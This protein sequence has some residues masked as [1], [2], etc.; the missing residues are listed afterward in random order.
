MISKFFPMDL[1][2]GKRKKIV[3]HHE[4]YGTGIKGVHDMK[5]AGHFALNS[6]MTRLRALFYFPFM[7]L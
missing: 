2:L 4:L 1:I 7:S 5:T 6:A 3:I